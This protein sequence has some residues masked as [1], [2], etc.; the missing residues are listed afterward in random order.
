[1]GEGSEGVKCELELACLCP[2]KMGFKMTG[3]G[4]W[5]MGMGKKYPKWEWDK[6][7]VTLTS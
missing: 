1:M 5:S 7:F 2:G 6:Y 4:I 3:T